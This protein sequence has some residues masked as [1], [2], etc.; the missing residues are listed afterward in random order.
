MIR[1][2]LLLGAF[3]GSTNALTVHLRSETDW[4]L[5]RMDEWF[6][7]SPFVNIIEFSDANASSHENRV[8]HERLHTGSTNVL[9]AVHSPTFPFSFSNQKRSLQQIPPSCDLRPHVRSRGGLHSLGEHV[10]LVL[11][12]VRP[13]KALV[14]IQTVCV[15]SLVHVFI[16]VTDTQKHIR[17]LLRDFRIAPAWNSHLHYVFH[18]NRTKI[19]CAA[20]STDLVQAYS[21]CF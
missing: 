3:W 8:R 18:M 6:F 12:H 17:N 5:H 7:Q 14:E 15:P 10:T 21:E 13:A 1:I 11:G 20:N 16:E 4:T 9:V 19:V 2:F